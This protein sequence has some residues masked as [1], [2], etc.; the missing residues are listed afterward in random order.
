[1]LLTILSFLVLILSFAS[2]APQIRHVWWSKNARGILSI[3]LLFNLICS[4]EHVFFGFFYM[5]NSY[6]VP[7]VWSHSPINILDWV[8]LVQLTGVWVLF[9]VLFFLC[10]YFN[11]LSRLQ[12]A[13]IIAI[14]V[15]FLS[16]FLVPLIIDATTD[17]FCP[18]ERPNCSIMD[19]DPLAFFEGFHNFYVMP[20]TVTLLVLGFY[21][22]AERP[23]LN[24]NITGLKLQTAIFVLS[25]VSW[26]V[27]LYFPWKMF[28]DQPWG[29]VPIYLVIPSWWQ[30]VGFVAGYPHSKQ[31]IGKQLYD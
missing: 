27:R 2:F 20:I 29:P 9:N 25:A 4:T 16:I 15:Y 19:R 10:L 3:H 23:L 24:L 7:G 30:Q 5:V 28:L 14:Y 26:I 6:H 8:N 12:K 18:P 13:L 1:M 22:Q 17:I 31:L 21:K 11:P